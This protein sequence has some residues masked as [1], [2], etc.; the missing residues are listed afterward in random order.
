MSATL[1]CKDCKHFLAGS[2]MCTRLTVDDPVWGPKAVFKLAFM[3]R[4]PEDWFTAETARAA[5]GPAG[6]FWEKRRW[7]Q[8]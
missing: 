7:W 5:C 6:R 3:E 4:D 8:L 1:Y 2:A